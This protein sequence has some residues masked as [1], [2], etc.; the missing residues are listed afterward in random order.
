MHHPSLIAVSWQEVTGW[1]VLIDFV[2]IGLTLLSILSLKKNS[3]SAFA[4]GMTVVF[5]PVMGL[6]L[7][8]LFGYQSVYRPLIK[9]RRH[10]ASYR[11][12]ATSVQSEE[13]DNAA[14]NLA[15]RLGASRRT[16]GNTVDLYHDGRSTFDAMLA[17]I[18][19]AKKHIHLEFFIFRPDGLGQRFLDALSERARNGVQV[20]L[21]Y[22]AVGSWTMRRKQLQGLI[23]SGGQAVPFLS[24]NPLRRSIQINLRN[25][26]KLLVVDGRVAFTGGFNIGDEYL[27]LHKF[28]GPWRDTFL[29]LRGPT[30]RHMQRMFI[31]DWSFAA[32]EELNEDDYVGREEPT[33]SVFAQIACSGPDQEQKPIREIYFAAIVGAQKRIWI[34]S[35]YFV[36]DP[37]MLDALCL[38]A[39]AGRDV[40]LLMPFRPDKWVPFLAARFYWPDVL[41]AGVKIYQYTQGFIHSKLMIID[42]NW[43]SVGSAN[44]DFRS[45]YLNFEMTCLMESKEVVDELE[46]AYLLDLELSI[47]VNVEEFEKRGFISRLAEN[48]CRLASPIL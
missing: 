1:L 20:R 30:V 5:I 15:V 34:T 3:T 18:R 23:G 46:T 48:A 13:H 44:L 8:W 26:R 29:R 16:A 7:Y 36:P 24:I 28:F 25:H 21:L 33:G 42:D 35:P 45:M 31:E 22:D 19:E 17:A 37:G 12:R 14:S 47:H 43:S 9:K 39:R 41:A 4:W 2:L 27:G 6:V 10:A 38:A 11:Q 32:H 40:R